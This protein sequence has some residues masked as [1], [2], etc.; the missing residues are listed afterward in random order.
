MDMAGVTTNA[1]KME[2]VVVFNAAVIKRGLVHS[3]CHNAIKASTNQ[4]IFRP[5]SQ[6]CFVFVFIINI[7]VI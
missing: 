5:N 2:I 4:D 7:A 1:V 6:K 3:V